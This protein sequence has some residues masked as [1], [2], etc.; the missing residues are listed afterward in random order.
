MTHCACEVQ[1]NLSLSPIQLRNNSKLENPC[2]TARFVTVTA[3]HDGID[4]VERGLRIEIRQYVMLR[5]TKG[6]CESWISSIWKLVW[7]QRWIIT[8]NE[9]WRERQREE[10]IDNEAA[11]CRRGFWQ[12]PKMEKKRREA[13][14]LKQ[15]KRCWGISTAKSKVV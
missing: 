11:R 3:T 8:K 2:V 4:R 10:T 13:H 9:H 5:K 7:L 1:C 12:L 14:R 6:N 15:E